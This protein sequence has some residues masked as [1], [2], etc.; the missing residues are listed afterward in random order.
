MR[1]TINSDRARELALAGRYDEAAALYAES[2]PT[3]DLQ[4]QALGA[5]DRAVLAAMIQRRGVARR[6]LREA[7]RLDPDCQSASENVRRLELEP[8][9][10]V[11]VLVISLL[12]NWPSTGGGTIHTQ[13]LCTF[14][15][16]AS[17]QAQHAYAEC[18]AFGVGRV[19][20]PLDY[21]SRPLVF[22]ESSW[23][24]E[25][26]RARF[27]E[28][29]QEFDPDWVIV[30]DSWNTK[31]LLCE[32]VREWPY[33]V[34][35]AALESLCPLNNVRLLVADGGTPVQCDQNQLSDPDVCRQCVAANGRCSGGLHQAERQLGGFDQSDYAARLRT[36][37]AEAEAVLAVN[38]T[39]ADL[40]RPHTP[41]V[42]VVPS[43]FNPLRF[44]EEIAPRQ[45]GP[46]ERQRILFAGLTDEFMKG[47]RVLR[48]AA[49]A[50]W[51]ERQDFE[52]VVTADSGGAENPYT[53][54]IGWQSQE[55]LPAVMRACD[56]VAFPTV[57]QE[58]LG[59]SAVEA[60][61]CGRP[62]VASRLGGLPWVVEDGVT[63]LLFEPADTH[64][65]VRQLARLLDD[66]ELAA[67][68]GTA[69]RRKFDREF[70][71]DT[72]IDRHYRTLLGEPCAKE[73][74][75]QRP[76][77]RGSFLE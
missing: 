34:R 54:Y 51:R 24:A 59:R 52:L 18:A 27:R 36:A 13:E 49:A 4:Q 33:F 65:L 66:P 60:M 73:A 6:W 37:F 67:R 30:T 46:E 40:V 21:D 74:G 39:I 75:S 8:R 16:R 14:L 43:G 15:T 41:A 9:D 47:F 58:A 17:Y 12:F 5:N 22:D 1:L 71:W 23:N 10:G 63:G 3:D 57:A 7:L 35:I 76:G 11:R 55:D 56:I 62:V 2:E 72:I 48:A 26:I 20:D 19:T 53:H 68:L 31:P 38:P 28:A 32:A 44:P 25:S 45:R 64:S 61:G 29:A 77:K 50:L 42:H 69:G 70:T